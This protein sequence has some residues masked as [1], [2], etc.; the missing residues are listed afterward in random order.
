MMRILA[1]KDTHERE[2]EE[3]ERLV[4]PSPKVKPPR[5]DLR[6][7]TTESETDPDLAGDPDL[8]LN[9]KNVGGS[10]VD[11][12]AL[13]FVETR[14]GPG[15]AKFVTVRDKEQ[16]KTVSVPETTVKN[17]LPVIRKSRVSL[18]APP[19]K[20]AKSLPGLFLL[21]KQNPRRQ[22][23]KPPRKRN[24]LLSHQVNLSRRLRIG[25]QM[26]KRLQRSQPALNKLRPTRNCGM[27]WVRT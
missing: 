24:R 9:Y 22:R 12:V 4:K 13:R 5:K 8:S 19:I 15:K 18:P 16:D 3:A 11:R 6:R 26:P 17:N 27:R 21:R 14:K 25:F 23:I 20:K 1:T 10:L 7:Q 2:D